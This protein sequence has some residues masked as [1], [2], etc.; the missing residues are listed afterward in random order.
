[1]PEDSLLTELMAEIESGEEV[2]EE[3]L[4]ARKKEKARKSKIP[5]ITSTLQQDSRTAENSAWVV[6]W[7]FL[8]RNSMQEVLWVLKN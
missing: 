4:L 7:E 6:K 8:P 5:F 3:P 2:V 1:M